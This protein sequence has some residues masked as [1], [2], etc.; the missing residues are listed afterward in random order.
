MRRPCVEGASGAPEPVGP[1]ALFSPPPQVPAGS[2]RPGLRLDQH[3]RFPVSTSWASNL[4]GRPDLSSSRLG[5][6]LQ[7]YPSSRPPDLLSESLP[8]LGP[9][10][11]RG[12]ASTSSQFPITVHSHP[13]AGERMGPQATS[14]QSTPGIDSQV[15]NWV[16]WD[17]LAAQ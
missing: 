9:V 5:T 8:R 13:Q 11:V 12:E 15:F 16:A 4:H 1:H 14:A 17:P 2:L 7:R 6:D 3:P 10:G